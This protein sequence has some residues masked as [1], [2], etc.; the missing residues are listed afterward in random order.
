MP[1]LGWGFCFQDRRVLTSTAAEAPIA[2]ELE[3]R[4]RGYL[5]TLQTHPSASV[6]DS[7]SFRLLLQ[8]LTE[9]V[10]YCCKQLSLFQTS[11]PLLLSVEEEEKFNPAT[12]IGDYQPITA[13]FVCAI[14]ASLD[15]R[16]DV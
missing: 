5:L 10:D 3:R 14:V 12:P 9:P 1:S 4:A 15:L 8:R 2:P 6:V 11:S 7:N 13:V 16:Q